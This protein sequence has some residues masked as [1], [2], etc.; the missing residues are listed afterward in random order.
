MELGLRKLIGYQVIVMGP[1]FVESEK[2]QSVKLLAVEDAGIWIESQEAFE[3]LVGN[4]A[5]KPT[6]ASMA[7]FVPFG[8]ITTIVAGLDASGPA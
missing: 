5:K 3:K 6:A 4:L 8:Q 2:L 7:F 1:R